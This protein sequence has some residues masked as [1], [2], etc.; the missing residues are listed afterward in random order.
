MANKGVIIVLVVIVVIIA[1][2][3]SK[4]ENMSKK[5][6][7]IQ[8]CGLNKD[9]MD[10]IKE[11]IK[12][13]ESEINNNFSI[14]KLMDPKIEKLIKENIDIITSYTPEQMNC[15][16]NQTPESKQKLCNS[17]QMS[18]MLQSQHTDLNKVIDKYVMNVLKLRKYLLKNIIYN[19]NK[20]CLN[21]TDKKKLIEAHITEYNKT[22]TRMFQ[23]SYIYPSEYKDILNM[24]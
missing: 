24:L 19:L 1:Y 5:D 23:V 18:Q 12:I 22:I 17:L 9:N 20:D 15:I 4:K 7:L 3:L 2:M 6:E 11:N 10:K 16:L 14:N 8:K 21:I 13:I